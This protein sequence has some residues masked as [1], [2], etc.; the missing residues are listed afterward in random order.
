MQD[1]VAQRVEE[2]RRLH[3]EHDQ[4]QARER[5]EMPATDPTIGDKIAAK[6]FGWIAA[7]I[8]GVLAVLFII[9]VN[10]PPETIRQACEKRF[11]TQREITEC[12]F[13]VTA[14]RALEAQDA[15]D[16]AKARRIDDADRASR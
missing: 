14:K 11:Y 13:V 5:L 2:L 7:A 15:A 9:G 3:E 4:R 16:R 6:A 12:E 1:S 10:T 8:I